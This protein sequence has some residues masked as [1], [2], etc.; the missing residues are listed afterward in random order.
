MKVVDKV[1]VVIEGMERKTND[2]EVWFANHQRVRRKKWRFLFPTI[3]F[4]INEVHVAISWD[5]ALV[6]DSSQGWMSRSRRGSHTQNSCWNRIERRESQKFGRE[7]EK[8]GLTRGFGRENAEFSRM[9]SKVKKMGSFVAGEEG[10]LDWRYSGS[11]NGCDRS[12][13]LWASY[14]WRLSNFKSVVSSFEF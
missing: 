6:S 12:M 1:K 11:V 9:M 7:W 8:F 5:L 4:G 2:L 13:K 14:A 3:V 10:F